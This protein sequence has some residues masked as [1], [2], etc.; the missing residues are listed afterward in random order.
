MNG[1]RPDHYTMIGLHKLA[2]Q[3]GDGLVPELLEL[4]AE[5][6]RMAETYPNVTALSFR[7]MY[8]PRRDA[9]GLAPRYRDNILAFPP[10]AIGKKNA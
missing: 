1:E 9:F 10:V 5:R 6:G 2:E 7:Q 8:R 3:A 4:M